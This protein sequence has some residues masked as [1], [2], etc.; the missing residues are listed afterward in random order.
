MVAQDAYGE[1][2]GCTA[3]HQEVST[4]STR[5]ASQGMYNVHN[6]NKAEPTVALKPRGDVTRN[7]KQGYQWPINRTCVHQKKGR[8]ARCNQ[9]DIRDRYMLVSAA[10]RLSN[11]SLSQVV[12]GTG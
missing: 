12:S 11:R 6:E 4:C 2:T 1:V 10:S 9:S 8:C 3:G 5:G 7:P